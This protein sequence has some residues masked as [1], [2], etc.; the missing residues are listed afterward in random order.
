MT[1][2]VLAGAVRT[3]GVLAPDHGGMCLDGVLPAAAEVLG[4]DPGAPDLPGRGAA[5][6]RRRSLIARPRPASGIG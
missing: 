3:G 6:R 5:A 2:D 4:L 1:S